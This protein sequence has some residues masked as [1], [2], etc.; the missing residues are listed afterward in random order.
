M[1]KAPP[2][3][4]RVRQRLNVPKDRGSGRRKAGY[5]FKKSI[6]KGGNFAGNNKGQT[7]E[8]TK[9]DPAQSCRQTP[10]LQIKDGI[11]R[12]L[13]GR[14]ESGKKT[15]RS[16]EQVRKAGPFSVECRNQTGQQQEKPF[17]HQYLALNIDYYRYVHLSSGPSI[18]ICRKLS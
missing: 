5:G 3:Q 18:L 17:D 7:A 15:H 2:H 12:F 11:F 13:T 9:H 14:Q 6:G 4:A 16:D 10:F 1:G 8:D